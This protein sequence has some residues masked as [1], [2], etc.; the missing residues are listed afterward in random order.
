[1]AVTGVGTTSLSYD[2]EG[3]VTQ[4]TY[5]NQS[6]NTFA[7]NGLS[8]RVSKVDSGGTKTYLRD[9]AGV[10]APVL[11]D[12]AASYT[13]GISE[14][15][16]STTTFYH[17]GIK[18]A[19][20]QSNTSETVTASVTFDAFGN[21]DTSSGTWKGPFAYGGPFGYQSDSDSGL[22]L[23]GHRYYDSS[24]GRFLT[25]DPIKSGRNWHTYCGGNPLRF[26]DPLGHFTIY[27]GGGGAIGI[28]ISGAWGGVNLAI[29]DSGSYGL[30]LDGNLGLGLGGGF[31]LGPGLG[32]SNGRI[33]TGGQL[34]ISHVIFVGEG[35]GFSGN[36]SIGLD[37]DGSAGPFS[38]SLGGL[39]GP[40]LGFGGYGGVGGSYT[41]KLGQV[42]PLPVKEIGE[43]WDNFKPIIVPI[44][45]TPSPWQGL[46]RRVGTLL[47]I[48]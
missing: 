28:G 43:I 39:V 44:A 27:A 30:V 3:R 8:T 36:S 23:L 21:P 20:T 34:Q 9:G 47:G 6:T 40:G 16:S 32:V 19:E 41:L 13:P 10:T 46:L 14:R 17:G 22:M 4:I 38:G 29:D 25:K 1:V 5:P 15:R 35:A 31:T 45:P 24:T 12:G 42:S 37:S 33:E 48:E 2:Y 7:Y 26:A 18:N 11:S